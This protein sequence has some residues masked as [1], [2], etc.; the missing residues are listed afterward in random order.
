[1]FSEDFRTL[2]PARGDDIKQAHLFLRG[3]MG[4]D[5]ARQVRGGEVERRRRAARRRR[6]GADMHMEPA[7]SVPW[8]RLESLPVKIPHQ[9]H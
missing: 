1:M 2:P 9:I 4:D 3:V 8:A 7:A 5:E 6:G